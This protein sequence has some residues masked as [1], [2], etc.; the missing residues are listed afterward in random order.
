[1]AAAA[2]IALVLALAGRHIAPRVPSSTWMLWCALGLCA[3]VGVAFLWAL[4]DLQA[5][6]WALRRGGTEIEQWCWRDPERSDV[7]APAQQSRR[8]AQARK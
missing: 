6:H 4:V 1:V 5:R 3:F 2:V 8:D 7:V